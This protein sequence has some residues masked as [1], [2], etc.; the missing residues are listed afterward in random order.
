[1]PKSCNIGCQNSGQGFLSYV[2]ALWSIFTQN[3][4]TSGVLKRIELAGYFF[5]HVSLPYDLLQGNV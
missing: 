4:L 3:L 5:K 1:M 2:T